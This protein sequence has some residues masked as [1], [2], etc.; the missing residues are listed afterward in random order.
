MYRMCRK[1]RER[2][3]DSHLAFHFAMLKSVTSLFTKT[4]IVSFIIEYPRKTGT[5]CGRVSLRTNK[6][7]LFLTG[8]A[9]Q[10]TIFL[11][12]R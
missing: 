10:N 2:D 12:N 7:S 3:H 1:E 5:I 8:S 6:K 9:T 11:K 4:C